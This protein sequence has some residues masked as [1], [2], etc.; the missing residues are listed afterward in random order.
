MKGLF[1]SLL[2]FVGYVLTVA[3]CAHAV[4]VERYSKLFFSV[5]AAWTPLYFLAYAWTPADVWV[6]PASWT[7]MPYRLDL[8]Y[9]YALFAMNMHNVLDFFFGVN[10][11]FSTCLL[12]EIL[13]TGRKGLAT[14]ELI[15][16]F[17]RPDGTDKIYAWR[18]PRLAETGYIAL[19]EASGSCA[20]TAKG[21]LAARVAWLGKRMLNLG[22]GG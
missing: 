8:W 11:G 19:D 2:A 10:G 17:R 21:A 15:S 12:L 5:F 4:R 18:L 13:K 3:F 20:L 16:K 9:G 22:A 7:G 1:I 6:L 14:E